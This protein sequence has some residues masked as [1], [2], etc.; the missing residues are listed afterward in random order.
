MLL[1]I[2]KDSTLSWSLHNLKATKTLATN[3]SQ[4]SLKTLTL[5]MYPFLFAHAVFVSLQVKSCENNNNNNNGM[6]F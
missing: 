4:G 1:P 5:E 6:R 2:A 3:E